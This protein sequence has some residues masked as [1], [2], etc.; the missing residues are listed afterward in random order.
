MIKLQKPIREIWHPTVL[1][2]EKYKFGIHK[3]LDLRTK[4]LSFPTGI[5]TPI[6]AVASG[7]WKTVGKSKTLGNYIVLEHGNGYKTV[8][9]HLSK[10][11][12]K[13]GYTIV[14][15]GD[16]IGFSGNTGLSTGPHLHFELWRN[17]RRIDPMLGIKAGEDFIQ[18]VRAKAMLR[19]AHLGEIKMLTK[20]G[21]KTIT[22]ENC[23]ELVS[24][25]AHGI[26]ERDYK[27]LLNLTQ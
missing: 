13:D 16:I 5:G 3:G 10:T 14:R 17:G 21:M 7:K 8:Y 6:H 9:A 25:N 24:K 12:Y 20:T 23:W 1:F 15:A 22:K 11:T 2:N 4:C 27:T 19:V 18:F 26:S